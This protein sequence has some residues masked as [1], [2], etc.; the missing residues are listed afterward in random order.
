M[1]PHV[2]AGAVDV[3]I[4]GAGIAGLWLARNLSHLGLSVLLLDRDNE[5]GSGSTTRNEGWLHRGTYF[6]A[7]I[8]DTPMAMRVAEQVAY[9]YHAIWSLYPDVLD[10]LPR[11]Y[12]FTR[13]AEVARRATA[14]WSDAGVPF[15]EVP[16][17]ILVDLEPR[18]TPPSDAVVFRV[19]DA[20]IDTSRL[21]ERL[22]QDALSRGLRL[23]PGVQIERLEEC[24]VVFHSAAGRC[25][26]EA[27]WVVHAT[28]Y[29]MRDL[30]ERVAGAELPIRFWKSH[31]LDFPRLLT[32]NVFSI[33]PRGINVFH[34][35]KW[36]IVGLNT[37]TGRCP[38]Q[39][40]DF[41]TDAAVVD[42]ILDAVNRLVRD[43][44]LS[45]YQSRACV[46]VDRLRDQR[47]PQLD[48]D[49][50]FIGANQI[51]VL[52]GKLTAAPYVAREISNA[53]YHGGAARTL[54]AQRP[55]DRVNARVASLV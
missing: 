26:V 51:W 34:H 37:E 27:N 9:G 25:R 16:R 41:Q 39:C 43:V 35:D 44:E 8:A 42:E 49:W 36:S 13:S 21:C 17:P 6:A 11:S 22:L 33:D 14:R 20:S 53:I 12:A 10:Q 29:G 31:L 52:P 4:I 55:I 2:A 46:K 38:L 5:V 30:L 1:S 23:E 32:R 50:G 28:G 54:V 45:T 18:L 48:A 40:P 7:S 24:S 19:D 15:E 47:L 3:V